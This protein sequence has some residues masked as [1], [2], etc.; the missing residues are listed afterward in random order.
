MIHFYQTYRFGLGGV[1]LGFGPKGKGVLGL[2]KC[3]GFNLR[4]GIR[5]VCLCLEFGFGFVLGK[6]TQ[7]PYL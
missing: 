6:I 2:K 7:G 3:V 1:L 5:L 4:K